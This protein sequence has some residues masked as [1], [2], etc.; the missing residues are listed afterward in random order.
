M[1]IPYMTYNKMA[2][3]DLKGINKQYRRELLDAITEV[4]DSGWYILGD[5]VKKF[6]SSFAQY[7]GVDRVIGTGNGLDALKLIFEGYKA[8][9]IIRN[10]DEVIAPANT[11]IASLLAITDAGLNPVL[12]EPDSNTC[13]IDPKLIEEKITNKTKAIMVVHLYG[14]VTHMDEI[15]DIAKKHGLKVIEDTAQAAGANYKGK[16]A[17]SLGDANGM[18]LFP[19]KNLGALGDAGAISTNDLALAKTI[20]DMRYFT[21][22]DRPHKHF[23]SIKS[24]MDELHG[25]VLLVKL[26]YLDAD[27]SKRQAIAKQYFDKIQ[28]DLIVL[29][30]VQEK[31]SHVFH[32]FVVRVENRESAVKHL[33]SH[34][35]EPAVHYPVAPH[36]NPAMTRWNKGEYPVTEELSRTVLSLP[37]FP[38]MNQEQID[39]VIHACNSFV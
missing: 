21:E 5:K 25:A 33:R 12:V 3:Y 37:I 17:G 26:K 38:T 30:S 7:L 16:K 11:Y 24:R 19:T 22:H 28:N 10:G 23:S 4:L 2:F 27:N 29:P 36:E 34:G 31:E 1:K 20:K 15:L 18:S 13:N 14:Q 9:G 6:E 32:L 8:L 39:R 35:V